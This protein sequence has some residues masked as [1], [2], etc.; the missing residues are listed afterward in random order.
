MRC[1]RVA[2]NQNRLAF[3]EILS[4][5]KHQASALSTFTIQDSHANPNREAVAA[6]FSSH[7][8]Q[9]STWAPWGWL[10]AMATPQI[11]KANVFIYFLFF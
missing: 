6:N 11:A 5:T 4:L 7:S 9:K 1:F 3:F 10:V 2:S 8:P